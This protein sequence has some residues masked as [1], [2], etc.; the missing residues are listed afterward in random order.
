MSVGFSVFFTL[1][2]TFLFKF[3]FFNEDVFQSVCN[4]TGK[5]VGKTAKV[6][7]LSAHWREDKRGF[8]R[9]DSMV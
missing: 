7:T 6:D 8:G 1:L 5:C 9:V 2:Q 4:V 3:F